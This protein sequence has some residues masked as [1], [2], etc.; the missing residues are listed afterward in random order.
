MKIKYDSNIYAEQAIIHAA[1]DYSAIAKVTVKS[2]DRYI[3]CSFSDCNYDEE[4]TIKEFSNYIID[5]MN[6]ES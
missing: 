6:Q 4:T 3:E 2:S 1:N 5:R